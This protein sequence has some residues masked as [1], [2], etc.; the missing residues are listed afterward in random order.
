MNS[1]SLNNIISSHCVVKWLKHI[2]YIH[3][4]NNPETEFKTYI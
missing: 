1:V 3:G 4:K 2:V